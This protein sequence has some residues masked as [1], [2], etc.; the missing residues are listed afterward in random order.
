M[1][2]KKKIVNVKSGEKI[3]LMC[4]L[5]IKGNVEDVDDRYSRVLDYCSVCQA[6]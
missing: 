1:Y 4:K 3:N 5:S 2:I 6:E